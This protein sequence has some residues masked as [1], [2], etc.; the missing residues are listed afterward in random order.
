MQSTGPGEPA[1]R[2]VTELEGGVA[3]AD[4]L[5]LDVELE[6]VLLLLLGGGQSSSTVPDGAVAPPVADSLTETLTPPIPLPALS[7]VMTGTGTRCRA[8]RL[9]PVAKMQGPPDAGTGCGQ[10][11]IDNPAKLPNS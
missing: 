11:V 1:D 5:E 9:P 4:E 8:I 10:G 3:L 6:L 2:V 7:W